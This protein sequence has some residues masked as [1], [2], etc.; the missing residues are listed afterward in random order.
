MDTRP[1]IAFTPMDTPAPGSPAAM[2]SDSPL[3]RV[4][5]AI[6]EDMEEPILERLAEDETLWPST[7]HDA[8]SRRSVLNVYVEDPSRVDAAREAVQRAAGALGLSLETT[9]SELPAEN[10]RESWRRFFH[11]TRVSPR[12]VIR[13]VWEPY[14]A[15]PGEVVVD[16]EPGMSF[17]TGS[18]G[19]TRACLQFLDAL[20]L[21]N[22]SRSVLDMGCGSGILSIAAQKLGFAP[23]AGFDNDPDAVGIARE[24]AR[25]NNAPGIDF[26]TADLT[27]A[28]RRADVVVANILAP[29]LVEHAARIAQ[30]VARSPGAALVV[31]GILDEQYPAVL[32]A[33]QTLGFRERGSRLID[34]WRSGWL[35]P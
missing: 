21:E 1:D 3:W 35:A 20:A 16:M 17:G 4:S 12:V 14:D 8:D 31:S 22:P 34:I 24:N 33:F 28:D 5:A 26:F 32:A 19:T 27:R 15:R 25:L 29:V 11:V 10:W 2:R 30:S 18:H 7:H 6:P 23:V 13:P 9:A